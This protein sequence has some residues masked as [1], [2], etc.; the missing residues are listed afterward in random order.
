VS[1]LSGQAP[2]GSSILCSL[3]GSTTPLSAATL[4]HLYPTKADYL[5]AYT[6]SLDSAISK[7]YILRADRTG[8]LAQARQ[9]AVGG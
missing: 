4:A 1:T 9:A 2:A 3:F 8:L 7:G 5:A 6:K